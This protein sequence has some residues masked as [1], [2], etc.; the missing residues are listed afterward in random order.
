MHFLL[1]FV[2]S[3]YFPKTL[4]QIIFPL[5]YI[6]ALINPHPNT[7]FDILIFPIFW[8]RNNISIVILICFSVCVSVCECACVYVCMMHTY[9]W[10]RNTQIVT[11]PW[12]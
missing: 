12:S 8:E 5:Q 3:V 6:T 2:K 7:I 10:P 11:D 4:N 1:H 9:G